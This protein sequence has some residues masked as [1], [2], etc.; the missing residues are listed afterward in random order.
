MSAWWSLWRP[1]RRNPGFHLALTVVLALGI[2]VAA[3]M[4]SVLSAVL[5]RPLPFSQPQQL[6]T[7]AEH[8]AASGPL[9]LFREASDPDLQDW[10]QRSHSLAHLIGFQ[11]TEVNLRAAGQSRVAIAAE[12]D[13]DL[14][15]TL[16]VPPQLGR[17]F[18]S[19]RPGN[20]AGEAVLGDGLWRSFFHADTNVVGQMLSVN[21]KP[22]RIAGVMPPGFGFP[23]HVAE[24]WLPHSPPSGKGGMAA[25][26][27]AE[28]DMGVV[29]R[30]RPEVTPAQAEAELGGIQAGIAGEYGKLDL[31]AGVT[32]ANL[33]AVQVASVRPTLLV[34]G[35]L[36]GVVWLIACA[37]AAGLLLT[38]LAVRRRELAVRTA[39]GA[40]RWR[41][42][43]QLLEE[44]APASLLACLLGGALAWGTVAGLRSLLVS[45]LPNGITV[46]PDS[47]V[48]MGLLALSLLSVGFA[49]VLPVWLAARPPATWRAGALATGDRSQARLRD[50]LTIVEVAVALAL[51]IGA[52]LLF[53][54]LQALRSVPLGFATDHI[55]TA[56]LQIPPLAFAQRDV[57][58]TLDL[59]LLARLHSL[60]GIS[61]AA[62]TTSLP[63][64]EEFLINEHYYGKGKPITISLAFASPEFLQVF[65]ISLLR[66][67]FFD[68]E[69]DI[70]EVRQVCVVNR[71]FAEQ[72]FPRQNPVGKHLFGGTSPVIVGEIADTHGAGAARTA[73]PFV[74]YSTGQLKL[75]GN[76][77]NS[78]AMF[79]QLAVRSQLPPSVLVPELRAALHAIAPDVNAA[80]VATMDELVAKSMGDQIFAARLLGLFA[81]AALVVALAGIYT[82]LAYAVSQRT[83][84]IGVRMALGAERRQITAMVLRRAAGLLT[85]GIA[86]GLVLAWTASSLLARFLFGVPPRDPLTLTVA[87]AA[88]L[89]AGLAAAW[90]PARHAAS[91][92][93]LI[94]L[95]SE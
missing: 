66:G 39:L 56:T 63:L 71:A 31:P 29:A 58:T 80:G 47:R 75:K 78:A 95:R 48:W 49:C 52:G 30:L 46:H 69:L 89:L 51:L 64:E 91:V 36:V 73:A 40:G 43:L 42:A 6:V 81:L 35:A 79:R 62:I 86:I 84:E 90:W 21:G 88:M 82:V 33:H 18:D 45:R 87:A 23:N 1:L 54:T 2:G 59:P 93:P 27:R 55:V 65:H 15:A 67:R 10:R 32:V 5:L 13:G 12:V 53:R 94:A 20:A 22:Y 68:P 16:E 4:F 61:A 70:P 7:I 38:R 44:C 76:L 19:S 34:V 14:S 72:F 41:L 9:H 50:G 28:A 3:A 17:G 25:A 11:T 26:R 37:A 8:S 83:R 92:S 85:V 74:M 24:L 60:P 77:Y 57:R